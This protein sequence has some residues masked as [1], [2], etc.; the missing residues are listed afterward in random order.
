MCG[1]RAGEQIAEIMFGLLDSPADMR[2]RMKAALQPK[3]RATMHRTAGQ[4][5]K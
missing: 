5:K 1:R 3:D 2:E 4:A